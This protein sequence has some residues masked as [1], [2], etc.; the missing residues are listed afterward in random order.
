MCHFVLTWFPTSIQWPIPDSFNSLSFYTGFIHLNQI[1]Y[2]AVFPLELSSH[3]CAHLPSFNS[4]SVYG[5]CL[6][7]V[8]VILLPNPSTH[9]TLL[10]SPRFA[11]FV[12]LWQKHVL[13][14]K[15]A[16]LWALV[17]FSGIVTTQRYYISA[18]RRA[19]STCRLKQD[20]CTWWS[21]EGSNGV[22]QHSL[23]SCVFIQFDIYF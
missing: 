20:L 21:N 5:L 17:I 19:P 9:F 10:L 15:Y 23:L 7:P 14:H 11:C 2:P 22:Q 3:L 1:V 18:P 13:S 8:P 12:L 16:I 4:L 6:L